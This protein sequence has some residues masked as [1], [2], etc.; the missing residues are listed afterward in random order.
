MRKMETDTRPNLILENKEKKKV[1]GMHYLNWNS[2]GLNS[3]KWGTLRTIAKRVFEIC[4]ID[5]FLE[6]ER[7]YIRIGFYYRSNYSL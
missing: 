4:S 5:N 6:E 2:F 3:W 1:S 7:E